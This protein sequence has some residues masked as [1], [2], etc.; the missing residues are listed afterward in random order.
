ML[1]SFIIPAHNEEAL[2][3]RTLASIFASARAIA[4][5]FEV[6]VVDDAST[7]HTADLAA[8]AGARV[9]HV[10]KRQIS[11]VRN[12]GA[13]AALGD[14]F[15]FIDADTI[16]T[17]R[18]L[19]SALAA[20]DRGA[21]GGGARVAMDNAMPFYGQLLAFLFVLGWFSFG[22]AAGCFIFARRSAFE[23]AGGFSEEVFIAEELYISEA[24]AKVGRFVI[25]SDR[26]MTSGRKF[27]VDGWISHSLRT[28]LRGPAGFRQREGLDLWYN[29]GRG[30]APSA[31]HAIG[32]NAVRV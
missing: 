7:D 27:H 12:A 6:V 26:V 9:I 13:R 3:P 23:A 11:A 30:P 16:L 28:L 17:P 32:E 24:L 20:L 29:C 31:S 25:L 5:P 14:I 18:T 10:N 8:A 4:L 19:R 15:I 1:I 22:W 21:V 2:L